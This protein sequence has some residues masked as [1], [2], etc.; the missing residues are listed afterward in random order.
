MIVSHLVCLMETGSSDSMPE[1]RHQ[2]APL[3]RNLRFPLLY[4][5]QYVVRIVTTNY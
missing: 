5:Q 4:L 1:G 2:T 3:I